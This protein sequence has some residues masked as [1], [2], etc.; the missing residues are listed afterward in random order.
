MS[1]PSQQAFLELCDGAPA[2]AFVAGEV[3]MRQGGGDRKG[4][5]VPM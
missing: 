2:E 5:G 1:T 4:E 3:L